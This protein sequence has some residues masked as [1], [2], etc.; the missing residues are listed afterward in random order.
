M[1]FFLSLDDLLDGGLRS[2]YLYEICG[3]SGS[4]KSYLC[5]R[6]LLNL[7]QHFSL[8]ALFVDT[9]N[10]IDINWI[11]KELKKNS[12]SSVIFQRPKLTFNL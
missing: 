9:T 7:V 1:T 10:N 2:R 5:R 8:H 11:F 3:Y 4:G 6:I 12:S